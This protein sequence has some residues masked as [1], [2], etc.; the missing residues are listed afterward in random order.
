MSETLP[1]S[2]LHKVI[3]EYCDLNK[4]KLEDVLRER[5]HELYHKRIKTF[6]CCKCTLDCSTY[7]KIISEKHWNALYE[8]NEDSD[9]HSCPLKL[10]NCSERFVPK[11]INTFNMSLAKALI[12]NEPNMLR[13]MIG[14]LCTSGFDAF[15]IVNQHILYHSMNQKKCCKCKHISYENT[16]KSLIT[17]KEWAKLFVKS[18]I[19]CP[20]MS[21]DCCCQYS[22]RNGINYSDIDDI[23][24]FKIFQ[25]AGP[26]SVLHK[27]E[28]NAF[29]Y[30][31]NWTVDNQHLQ[32]AIKELFNILIDKTFSHRVLSVIS[33][34]SATSI[35]ARRWV[36]TN[37]RQQK[38]QSVSIQTHYKVNN[39]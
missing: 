14:Q 32:R 36:S 13:Y 31:L 26:F 20:S 11:R 4:V 17:E 28:E 8:F 24:L 10:R 39:I 2:I 19:S 27:I 15:L 12:L 23:C 6:S 16:E 29:I 34:Q 1:A 18:D 35:D 30:F 22:V 25:I 37:L 5:K 3:S 33:S 21:K 9:L 7:N 38:V